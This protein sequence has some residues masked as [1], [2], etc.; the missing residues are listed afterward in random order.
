[1]YHATAIGMVGKMKKVNLENWAIFKRP[2][3]SR[4]HPK[5]GLGT[6]SHAKKSGASAYYFMCS[7]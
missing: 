2:A 3:S 4:S 6:R 1:M 5:I 7:R